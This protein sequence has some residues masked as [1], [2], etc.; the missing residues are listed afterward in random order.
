MFQ[1]LGGHDMKGRSIHSLV[2]GILLMWQ[3]SICPGA[4]SHDP[5]RSSEY[6]DAVTELSKHLAK[7]PALVVVVCDGDEGDLPTL[8]RLIE[9]TPWTVFCRGTISKSMDK[10]RDWARQKGLSGIRVY[11]VADDTPSL[12]L[13]GDMADAVWVA[14]GTDHPPS[15]EEIMRVLRPGGVCVAAGKVSTKPAQHGA[16]EWRHPYHSPDNN[17]VSRDSVSRLPGELRFQT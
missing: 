13:A 7:T 3:L 9:Q 14:P 6:L 1:Y 10:I 12:W 11:A 5:K 15:E 8:T 4:E 2:L 17:V 16:D